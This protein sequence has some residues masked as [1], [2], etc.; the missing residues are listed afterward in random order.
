MTINGLSELK[1]LSIQEDI[2]FLALLVLHTIKDYGPYANGLFASEIDELTQNN[3]IDA[4]KQITDEGYA[5][6]SR[7]TTPDVRMFNEFMQLIPTS[8][9]FGTWSRTT[10]LRSKYSKTLLKDLYQRVI[11]HGIPEELILQKFAAEVGRLKD[12]SYLCNNLTKWSPYKTLE[13]MLKTQKHDG[14]INRSSEN[15]L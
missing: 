13:D 3:L 7:L 10:A 15:I 2:S 4:E 11:K 1:N 12:S 14:V 8:D 6:L 5:V 9:K